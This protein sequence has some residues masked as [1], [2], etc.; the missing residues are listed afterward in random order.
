[1]VK[2]ELK[3]K[4]HKI[5]EQLVKARLEM[6]HHEKP[7]AKAHALFYLGI[8]AARRDESKIKVMDDLLLPNS[9]LKVKVLPIR[10]GSLTM[11]SSMPLVQTTVRHF[12]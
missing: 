10:A 4:P 6:S 11:I 3:K 1:M 5:R 7:L 8:S 12:F 2:D 9:P